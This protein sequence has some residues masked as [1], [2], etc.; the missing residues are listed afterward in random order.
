MLKNTT[1]MANRSGLDLKFYPFETYVEG[2][3][4]TPVVLLD[5]ANACNLELPSDMVWA[6][7]GVG[8]SRKVGFNNPFEGTL[9]ISTQIITPQIRAIQSG[10]DPACETTK[11]FTFTNNQNQRNRYYVIEADT[12]WKDTEGNIVGEHIIVYKALV[13]K[14]LTANYEG[15]DVDPQSMDIVFELAA[16]D[17]GRVCKTK[18]IEQ[19][20]ADSG[21]GSDSGNSN[22][23][24][25]NNGNTTP[26]CGEDSC[27][28]TPDDD[29]NNGQA[30]NPPDDGI[31]SSGPPDDL[32]DDDTNPDNPADPP[33][34]DSPIDGASAA[35]TPLAT[36]A[37]AKKSKKTNVVMEDE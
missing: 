22:D 19:E 29:D 13:N 3:D 7:G 28:C 17:D 35:I 36:T 9:T 6:T 12:V 8:K 32:P 21:D 15:G 23:G 37:S 33:D 10:Q 14:N 18:F 16:L 30:D 27:V 34:D 31:D 2:H 20:T 4:N 5:F 1:K 11:E 26:P 24:S 25:D